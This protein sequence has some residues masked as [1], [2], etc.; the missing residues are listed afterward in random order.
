MDVVEISGRAKPPVVKLVNFRKFKYIEAKKEREARKKTRETHT[1]EIWLG[2]TISEHDM[3]TRVRKSKDF[4]SKGD[5][6]KFTVKFT[7]REMA[8]TELGYKV[9]NIIEEK[10][11]ELAERDSDPKMVGRRL[12]TSFKPKKK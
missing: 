5:R 6:V 1:K 8:H 3:D 4:F 12:S 2:P 10:I 7:G 11:N 9:L